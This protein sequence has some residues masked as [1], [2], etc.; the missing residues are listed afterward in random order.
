M[1]GVTKLLEKLKELVYDVDEYDTSLFNQMESVIDD[2]EYEISN[3]RYAVDS[4]RK[5]TVEIQELLDNVREE[6]NVLESDIC[7]TESQMS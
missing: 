1:S 6:I 4:N 2:L 3:V 5:K 7:E